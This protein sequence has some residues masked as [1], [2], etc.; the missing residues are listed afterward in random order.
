LR[1]LVIS[2]RK[3]SAIC[4]TE[5]MR[6]F[7]SVLLL[8]VVCTS[9]GQDDKSAHQTA[10]AH[11]SLRSASRNGSSNDNNRELQSSPPPPPLDCTYSDF[12]TPP[13]NCSTIGTTQNARDTP[14]IIGLRWINADT[15]QAVAL[16]L[17]AYAPTTVRMPSIGFSSR[18]SVWLPR[19]PPFA[20]ANYYNDYN[21]PGFI[22]TGNADD[23]YA[24]STR[25]TIEAVTQGPIGSVT[26][27]SR[28][29][30]ETPRVENAA[31]WAL[32]ANNKADFFACPGRN[33][34]TSLSYLEA[35]AYSG[36]GGNGTVLD[37]FSTHIQLLR[38][39]PTTSINVYTPKKGSQSLDA[40]RAV[41]TFN[42]TE[43]GSPNM[44]FSLP[45]TPTVMKWYP[46]MVEF[47][48]DNG[49]I[50]RN[51]TRPPQ[52]WPGPPKNFVFFMFGATCEFAYILDSSSVPRADCSTIETFIP[53]LGRH[54]LV[55]SIYSG[56][57]MVGATRSIVFYVVV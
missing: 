3:F 51:I 35:T 55:T 50:V 22:S 33:F 4:E 44:T 38:T 16:P 47:N 42:L 1:L 40:S 29:G 24:L 46:T 25:W 57:D 21:I 17:S 2:H 10:S 45:V 14:K 37:R 48:Y 18:P 54:T 12:V 8:L 27:R 43:L 34:F 41:H 53:T 6:V 32:C 23:N 31:L 5:K 15:N 30:F 26:F 13:V 52:N 39:S 56:A 19:L 20:P 11:S 9:Y 36:K 7:V 49:T 28:S